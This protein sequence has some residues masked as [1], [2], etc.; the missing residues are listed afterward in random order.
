[1]QFQAPSQCVILQTKLHKTNSYTRDIE[2]KENYTH[3]T[4]FAHSEN[5]MSIQVK[6]SVMSVQKVM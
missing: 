4:L 1:M 5:D 3:Y 6:Y 2:L